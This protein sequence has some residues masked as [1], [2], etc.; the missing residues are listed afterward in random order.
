VVP[1]PLQHVVLDCTPVPDVDT[2]G[3]HSLE[4]LYK[5]LKA[6]DIVVR[7]Y[8]VQYCSVDTMLLVY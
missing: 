8:T 1:S 7:H 2:T 4:E 6:M 3:I 5:M